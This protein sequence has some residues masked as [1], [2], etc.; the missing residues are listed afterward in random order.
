MSNRMSE[1][2]AQ[3]LANLLAAQIADRLFVNGDGEE[4][5]RLMLLSPNGKDLGGFCK[6]AAIDQIMRVLRA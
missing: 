2:L 4:A 6:R 5:Q 3:R 1:Q